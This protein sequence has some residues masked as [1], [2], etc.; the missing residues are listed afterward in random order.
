MAKTKQPV[1]RKYIDWDSIEPLY[2]A[3]VLSNYEICSQ[4]AADHQHSQTWKTEITE[5]SIRLKAKDK[6]WRKN[7][8]DKIV[9]RTQEK[10]LRTDLRTA[11]NTDEQIIESASD[12]AVAVAQAQRDRLQTLLE[13]QDHLAVKLRAFD[14]PEMKDIM[15]K[16][17]AFKNIAY[18]VGTLQDRQADRWHLNDQTSTDKPRIKVGRVSA[19][20]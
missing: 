17:T 8:K 3:G 7:L 5:G 16:V 6:K 14:C 4:Y 1:K 10:L 12:T 2:R 15:D 19:N 9:E 13:D 11:T 18:T 20:E